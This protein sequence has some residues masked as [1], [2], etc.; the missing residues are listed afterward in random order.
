V[1][2]KEIVMG[3][4]ERPGT[5]AGVLPAPAVQDW[6]AAL[7]VWGTW[8]ALLLAGAYFIWCYGSC[9]PR[10][11][12]WTYIPVLTGKDEVTP[13]WLWH[14][15]Y[16]HRMPL[17]K[18]VFVAAFRLSGGLWA[19][20][21]LVLAGL[22][23]MAAGL[24]G[25]ARRLRG[26]TSYAD[27]FFPL[28]LLHWGQAQNLLVGFQIQFILSAGLATAVLIILL[29]AR[30]PLEPRAALLVTLCLTLLPLCGSNGVAYVPVLALWLAWNGVR[31][32]RSGA[33]R[34]K[35]K[36]LLVGVIAVIPLILVRLYFVDFERKQK[37]PDLWRSAVV[38]VQFLTVGFGQAVKEVWSATRGEIALV[39]W[40]VLALGLVGAGTA[41]WAAW[42]H[43]GTPAGGRALGLLA[44]LV[45]H[46]CL[47]A[48]IGWGR[49]G[50]DESYADG[51]PGLLPRLSVLAAPGLFA[52]YFVGETCTGPVVRRLVAMS[53]FTAV[54]IAWPMNLHDGL[55]EAAR[56]Y[57]ERAAA[58][59]RDLRAGVPASL[60]TERHRPHIY[61]EEEE[62]RDKEMTGYFE[63]LRQAGLE[64][65]PLLRD[66]P[67]WQDV[68]YR[69]K[70]AAVHEMVW[71]GYDGGGIGPSSYLRFDLKRPRFVY[72]IRFHC[73]YKKTADNAAAFRVVWRNSAN[74]KFDDAKRGETLFVER[75]EE[76]KPAGR[77]HLIAQ[78]IAVQGLA[79]RGGVSPVV[80]Q[81]TV[82]L[83][84]A[85][86]DAASATKPVTVWVNRKI[87]Q[88][89]VYPDRGPCAFHLSYI[90]L[91]VPESNAEPGSR[92]AP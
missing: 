79:S 29:R 59:E 45:A 25:A 56:D 71:D 34:G 74:E 14:E 57:R 72:A 22:A 40:A 92:P 1:T 37:E 36:G 50:S 77:T 23:G 16:D 11:D 54:A 10:A 3:E 64:P 76:A 60:L 73:W 7:F 33:S 62:D 19:S 46:A 55:E 5:A 68:V 9:I 24:I 49:G 4:S 70:P 2:P 86:F 47:A 91:L 81:A 90:Q 61:F 69:S 52:F 75:N 89:Q 8:L 38:A 27:A 88:F 48:G 39:G 80:P 58:F 42:R 51:Y 31:H 12:E 87:D 43:R 83:T 84:V 82:A 65:F 20:K 6:G 30:S 28:I 21:F 66:D 13:E 26:W 32:W 41:A 15:E 53:L 17:Q 63:A 78:A 85:E 35:A 18:L 67:E 44:F